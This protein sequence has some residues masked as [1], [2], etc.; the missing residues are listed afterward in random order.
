MK[1]AAI[2]LGLLVMAV[3]EI[4]FVLWITAYPY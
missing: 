4:A 1:L 3:F 2:I